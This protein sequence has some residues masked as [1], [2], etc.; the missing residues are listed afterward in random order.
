VELEHAEAL[1][2]EVPARA[3][4]RL[5]RL[6]AQEARVG[7]Q[8]RA[9]GPAQELVD[10]RAAHLA[11]EIPQ[12]DLDAADR[13]HAEPAAP[14]DHGAAVHEIHHRLDAQRVLS[15]D[16]RGQALLDHAHHRERRPVGEGL[17]Q[18]G[19]VLVGVHAHEDL[20]AGAAGPRRR[21]AHRLERDGERHGLD[22][23]DLHGG[24]AP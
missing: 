1:R 2:D 8:A 19:D 23:G 7:G 4:H 14:V 15:H 3:R 20:L 22:G 5:R 17:A 11:E 13:E 10:R 6:V 12:R 9:L 16:Q 21:R 24:Q 18:P